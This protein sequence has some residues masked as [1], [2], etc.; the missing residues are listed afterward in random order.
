[1]YSCVWIYASQF[2]PVMISNPRVSPWHCFLAVIT[3]GESVKDVALELGTAS[4]EGSLSQPVVRICDCGNARLQQD[5]HTSRFVH[6][7]TNTDP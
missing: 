6:P 4:S 3:S 7:E 5:D 2:G 1:M